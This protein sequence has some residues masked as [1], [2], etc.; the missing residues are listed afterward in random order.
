MDTNVKPSAVGAEL[1]VTDASFANDVLAAN[2]PVLVDFWAPWC[3][4]CRMIAPQVHELAVAYADRARV[5]KVN[6]DENPEIA[7]RYGI[8]GIPT[9]LIFKNG[10]VVDRVVGFTSAK[11]L[12]TKL[13]AQL[14]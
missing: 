14:N 3:G 8:S 4:P 2:Q 13:D 1:T 5:A 9:L 6:V 11:S 10:Q 12:A 7:A